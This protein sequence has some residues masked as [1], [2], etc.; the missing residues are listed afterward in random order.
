M[1]NIL[2]KREQSIGFITLN[3]PEK[4][5][6]FNREMAFLLQSVLDE[7][8]ADDNIKV[9]CIT[10]EGKAF[11]AGQDLGEI[12][13]DNAPGFDV[14]LKE[15]YNPII[16]RIR[17]INK[18]VIAAVNG[19]ATGA[20]A[21]IALACDIVVAKE[22]ATF[23]QAFSKIGLIPDCGGTFFLP[24]LIGL[25]KATAMMML[26]ESI[27]AVDAEKMGMIYK[28]V[29]DDNFEKELLRIALALTA[30]PTWG[31]AYTKQALNASL[32]QSFEQQLQTEDELQYK[33]AQTEDF[34]E[35]IAAFLEKRKP[36]FTGK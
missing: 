7:C 19:V 28:A 16:K 9:I 3:R 18:P 11:C 35:G 14:I 15:H 2:L 25:Q 20:G 5:N 23:V 31:L 12:T 13:S 30:Q 4:Y 27:N 1:A 6:A 32:H 17:D 29:A 10:S 22:S 26:G 8:A 21:N 36:V 34:K 33:A 24:R